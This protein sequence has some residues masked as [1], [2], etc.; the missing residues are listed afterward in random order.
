MRAVGVVVGDHGRDGDEP[1]DAGLARARNDVV[2]VPR[3]VGIVEVA[4]VIDEHRA[5]FVRYSPFLPLFFCFGA[6]AGCASAGIDIA[7]EGA[8]RGGQREAGCQA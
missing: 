5:A 3:E 8:G 6:A 7:R 1:P 4:V 2:A